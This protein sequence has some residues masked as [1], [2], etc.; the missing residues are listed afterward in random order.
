MRE[1]C[2][3]RGNLIVD[4]ASGPGSEQAIP[5]TTESL[6]NLPQT[7]PP[8]V[9]LL[10]RH[11]TIVFDWPSGGRV[12]N[13][14]VGGARA[15]VC[16][17]VCEVISPPT[18]QR[19]TRAGSDRKTNVPHQPAGPPRVIRAHCCAV[20]GTAPHSVCQDQGATGAS[21]QG[22]PHSAVWPSMP[23]GVPVACGPPSV[24]RRGLAD[25]AGDAAAHSLSRRVTS[26]LP[27]GTDRTAAEHVHGGIVRGPLRNPG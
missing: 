2:L 7:Q 11:S 18:G 6:W 4:R 15:P 14:W 8:A 9:V 26:L 10:G 20:P 5:R 17:C 25:R 12:C 23:L 13:A 3:S 1:Q 16:V 24:R 27:S 22:A 21:R 19:D